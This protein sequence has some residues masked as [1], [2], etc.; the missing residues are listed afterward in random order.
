MLHN[1]LT[2]VD[3]WPADVVS[4]AVDNFLKGSVPN[5]DGR[6]APTA[7]QLGSACRMAQEA[8]TRANY[9]NRIRTPALPP[10][11]IK[12][13]PEEQDRARAK[14]AE[15]ITSQ[16]PSI[17]EQRA[18]EQDRRDK[19]AKHDSFFADEFI[20]TPGGVGRISKTLA[21]KMGFSVGAPESDDAAA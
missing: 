19:M 5:F 3:D 9:L 20:P 1:Y 18:L 17:D 21:K 6:F 4:D 8:I 10:P 11:D 13:T 12:H 14:I 16:G 15:F 7:P 2:A